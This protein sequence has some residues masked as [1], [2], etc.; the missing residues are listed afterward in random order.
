MKTYPEEERGEGTIRCSTEKK[1]YYGHVYHIIERDRGIRCILNS[2][3]KIGSPL[4][5]TMRHCLVRFNTRSIIRLNEQLFRLLYFLSF[6][7]PTYFHFP[8]YLLTYFSLF[9][10]ERI[11]FMRFT[12]N[13]IMDNYEWKF[14]FFVVRRDRIFYILFVKFVTSRSYNLRERSWS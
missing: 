2:Q 14:I 13:A 6:P 1:R 7:S 10:V 9:V 5:A 12:I 11:F 3:G 4:C 8:S